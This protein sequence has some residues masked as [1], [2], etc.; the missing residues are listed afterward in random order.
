M[1]I[2]RTGL[3]LSNGVIYFAFASFGDRAPSHGWVFGY[4]AATLQRVSI[5]NSSPDGGYGGIWQSGQGLAADA[6]GYLYLVT[7]NGT[8]NADAGKNDHGSSLSLIRRTSSTA[9]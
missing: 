2:Q 6:D 7:G 9:A 1:E 4:D 8:F 3:L 5:F